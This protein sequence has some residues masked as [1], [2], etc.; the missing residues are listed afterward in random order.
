MKLIIVGG[1]DKDCKVV[2]YGKVPILISAL[3]SVKQK[4]ITKQNFDFNKEND[5]ANYEDKSCEYK[6]VVSKFLNENKCI[7]FLD[8]HGLS[9]KRDSIIDICTNDGINTNNSELPFQ[10]KEM[11]DDIFAD[12]S[13]SIDK[14]FKASSKNVIANYVHT[15]H[16]IISIQIEINEDYRL[17]YYKSNSKQSEILLDIIIQWLKAVIS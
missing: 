8:I 1:I 3:H 12:D 10:L 2:K 6:Q 9:K 15:Q 13:A 7:L 14:Y 17:F 4:R 5:D 11:I 16:N